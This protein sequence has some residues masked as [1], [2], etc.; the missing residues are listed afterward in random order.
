MQT[1]IIKLNGQQ[2]TRQYEAGGGQLVVEKKD[3]AVEGWG[4]K[5][6]QRWKQLKFITLIYEATKVLRRAAGTLSA[7]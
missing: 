7:R 5:G 4:K 1:T 3:S 2:A 6:E